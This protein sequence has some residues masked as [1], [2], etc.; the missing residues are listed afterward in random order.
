[1]SVYDRIDELEEFYDE[2]RNELSFYG[3]DKDPE[4]LL[5]YQNMVKEVVREVAEEYSGDVPEE[6]AGKAREMLA[7]RV[8]KELDAP[9]GSPGEGH[10]SPNFE[11]S[12]ELL[13]E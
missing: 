11:K 3:A 10:Q 4:T 13:G 5:E 2:N 7:G 12:R 6:Y 1:M 9:M 8:K